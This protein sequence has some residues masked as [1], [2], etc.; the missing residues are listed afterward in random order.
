MPEQNGEAIVEQA[1]VK[2]GISYQNTQNVVP[3]KFGE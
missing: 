1:P 2:F 3:Y